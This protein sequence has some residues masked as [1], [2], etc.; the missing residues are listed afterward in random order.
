M[1]SIIMHMADHVRTR[2]R[3][4]ILILIPTLATIIIS[5]HMIMRVM[6]NTMNLYMFLMDAKI[7]ALA[8]NIIMGADITATITMPKITRNTNFMSTMAMITIMPLMIVPTIMITTAMDINMTM[9]MTTMIVPI[10]MITMIIIM[11]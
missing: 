1:R 5:I 11:I 7:L 10:I 2:T 6:L 8:M 3:T 4:R 9:L